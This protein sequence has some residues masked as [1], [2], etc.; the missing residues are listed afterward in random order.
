[1]EKAGDR[2]SKGRE[3]VY[4]S[5]RRGLVHARGRRNGPDAFDLLRIRSSALTA[6]SDVAGCGKEKTDS[7]G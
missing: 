3:A 5:Q 6:F 2:R 7:A 1:M 4:F